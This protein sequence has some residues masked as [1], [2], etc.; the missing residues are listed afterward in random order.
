MAA[1]R[2]I[3]VGIFRAFPG[4]VAFNEF[5]HGFGK[6]AVPA[7]LIRSRFGAESLE[8]LR[9][10]FGE[11]GLGD[12]TEPVGERLPELK[13]LL[14]DHANEITDAAELD[15]AR[16]YYTAQVAGAE[17]PV[18]VD[19]GYSGSSQRAIGIALGKPVDALYFAR[20]EH[21]VEHADVYDLRA[22]AYSDNQQFFSSGGFLE[23][24][25]TPPFEGTALALAETD[26]GVQPRTAEA[27]ITTQPASAA[28]ATR[29]QAGLT[30]FI[31]ELL[32]TFGTHAVLNRVRPRMATQALAEFVERP[33]V[34]DARMVQGALGRGVRPV[35]RLLRAWKATKRGIRRVVR[36]ARFW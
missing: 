33:T 34:L 2:A 7:E 21:N 35:S 24:L 32:E 13:A 4:Q 25:I 14:T 30:A 28:F 36:R 1:S 19:F 12:G 6:S 26:S 22:E 31:G 9:P 20:M 27:P 15:A 16:A 17:R 29:V 5:V 18:V 11:Y 3:A 8:T 23:T 10:R